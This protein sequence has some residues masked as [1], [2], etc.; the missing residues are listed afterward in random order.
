M[1]AAGTCQCPAMLRKTERESKIVHGTD[2]AMDLAL[3]AVVCVPA[4]YAVCLKSDLSPPILG[5]DFLIFLMKTVDISAFCG[6][7][8]QDM[9]RHCGN[10]AIGTFSAKRG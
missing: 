8:H 9:Q 4:L 6:K 7:I 2:R 1:A 3:F 5:G 10:E